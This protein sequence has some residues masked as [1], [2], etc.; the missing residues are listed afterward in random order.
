MDFVKSLIVVNVLAS[1]PERTSFEL[2]FLFF[3]LF[4]Y[5]PFDILNTEGDY[6]SVLSNSILFYALGLLLIVHDWN[7]IKNEFKKE[8]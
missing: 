4:F 7:I 2:F 8:K 3:I 6:F 5:L 1:L